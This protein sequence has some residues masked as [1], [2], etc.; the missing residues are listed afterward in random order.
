MR[1]CNLLLIIAE[2][3]AWSIASGP[4][5]ATQPVQQA[6]SARN[7]AA[8]VKALIGKNAGNV[9][10]VTFADRGEHLVRVVRG[11][12]PP[13]GLAVA[14]GSDKIVIFSNKQIGA[15]AEVVSF[16][17][18]REQPVTV[19]RG[20]PVEPIPPDPARVA[21][22]PYLDLFAAARGADLDRVAFAV[23]GAESTHGADP[24]MW[25]AELGGPQGP[26]QV[27]AAAA[28]DSGGGRPVLT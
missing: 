9:K 25:R 5:I 2:V 26:M 4:A 20:G 24:A 14:R 16:A 21:R 7:L 1:W 28:V 17:D 10:L 15:D 27:S 19:L 8:Q 13:H 22:N 11:N 6:K 12:G 3:A 23:D 18:R